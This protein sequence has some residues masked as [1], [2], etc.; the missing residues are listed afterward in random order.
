MQVVL[1]RL[2]LE[3]ESLRD[4]LV[5]QPFGEQPENLL[6]ASGHGRETQTVHARPVV[7]HVGK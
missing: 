1:H 5:T 7:G 4:L 6:L 2:R 3:V